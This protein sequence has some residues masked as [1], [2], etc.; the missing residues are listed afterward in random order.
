MGDTDAFG[1]WE[2]EAARRREVLA[3]DRPTPDATRRPE[4]AWSRFTVR[5]RQAMGLAPERRQSQRAGDHRRPIEV[6]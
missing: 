1:T 2:I 4:A 5:A 6:R 3:A